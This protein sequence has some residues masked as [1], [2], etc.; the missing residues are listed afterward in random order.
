MD[1]IKTDQFRSC[2]QVGPYP[3]TNGLIY[4]SKLNSNKKY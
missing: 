3:K 2:M 1:I 4:I